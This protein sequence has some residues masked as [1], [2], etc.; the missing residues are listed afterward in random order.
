MIFGVPLKIC[1]ILRIFAV[2]FNTYRILYGFSLLLDTVGFS[3]SVYS[4]NAYCNIFAVHF[5]AYCT[6]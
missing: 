2:G 4:L 6:L 1:W 5:E 3:L